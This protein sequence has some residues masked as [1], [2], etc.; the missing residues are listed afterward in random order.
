MK[1]KVSIVFKHL[2]HWNKIQEI[3]AKSAKKAK[4]IV[5]RMYK[6]KVLSVNVL[7]NE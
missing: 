3:E 2:P 7:D 6:D 5:Y 1:Y 4:D